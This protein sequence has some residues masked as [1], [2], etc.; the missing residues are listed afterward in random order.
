MI[1]DPAR[2]ARQ[3]EIKR[4]VDEEMDAAHAEQG[5][6]RSQRF[7]PPNYNHRFCACGWQAPHTSKDATVSVGLH[8]AA[9]RKKAVKTAE[10]NINRRVMETRG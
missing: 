2:A 10:A 7:T 1:T 4:I 9:A 6:H 8:V 3:A 5:R